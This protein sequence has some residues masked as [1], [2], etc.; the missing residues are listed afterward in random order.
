MV[1]YLI[2]RSIQQM[3]W[4]SAENVLLT[5]CYIFH[6]GKNFPDGGGNIAQ[7]SGDVNPLPVALTKYVE[8]MLPNSSTADA[9]SAVWGGLGR[10]R[11]WQCFSAQFLF[12]PLQ[13]LSTGPTEMEN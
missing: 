12:A 8:M 7:T 3:L 6:S 4:R 13:S 9:P 2:M 5:F 10:G 1:Q 11:F